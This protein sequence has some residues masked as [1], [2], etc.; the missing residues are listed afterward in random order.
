MFIEDVMAEQGVLIRDLEVYAVF[1]GAKAVKCFPASL[2][3][4]QFAGRFRQAI[5]AQAA[6]AVHEF[7]LGG[8]LQVIKNLDTLITEI[9][10]EHSGC[11][12]DGGFLPQCPSILRK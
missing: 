4:T 10:L 9:D 12:I 11:G 6:K 5:G 1:I 2:E 7:E 8:F 3:R